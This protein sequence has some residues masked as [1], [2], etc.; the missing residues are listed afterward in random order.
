[1]NRGKKTNVDLW[2]FIKNYKTGA[3]EMAQW[4]GIFTA[5]EEDLKSVSSDDS[6]T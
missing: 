6:W 3:G 1:M 4:L 5:L 2:L